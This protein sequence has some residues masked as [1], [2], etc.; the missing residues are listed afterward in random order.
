MSDVEGAALLVWDAALQ[1]L[2]HGLSGWA[3]WQV[4]LFTLVF[5]H[6]TIACVTIFLHRSQAHRALDLHPAVAH[7]MRLWLWIGTGMVTKEWV[8]IHRKHHAKCETPDDP[9]SPQTRGIRTVLLQGSELYRAEAKNQDTLARYGHGTPDDWIERH[10]YSRYSW[11]GVGLTL[12][13]DL[14][15]FG[16]VGAAV[17]AVQMLWIPITA[18]GIINGIGHF[19]GYRNFEAPDA[20][21][22]VSPWGVII[23]GEE[24]HNNH[25]TYPT[26]AKLSVKK[27]EF[28]IG[29]VYIRSLSA[30]GLATVRKLPPKLQLGEVKAQ[31]D[32]ESLEAIIAHR[33][34]LMAAYARQVRQACA[35]ELAAAKARRAGQ[36][37]L[38]ELAPLQAAR[39]WLHRDESKVPPSLHARLAAARE[40]YPVLDKMV[41]MRGELTQMWSNTHRSRE[42]LAADLH[43]WCQRA[44][45]SGVEALQ[46]FALQLRAARV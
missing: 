35:A 12:I 44:E 1:W 10:L 27:G 32:H 3:W 6:I 30:L 40:A 2:G 11:Q 46:R 16:A 8:A 19:W 43:A 42:Q 31:A 18:A 38:A 45:Q 14:A 36:P 9:H 20:S 21:R 29:W 26:S 5:T 41:R 4:V 15:M 39:K 7:F 33:Y 25:H 28:D 23:G 37:S 22:N 24:L 13:F 34:E 17:W